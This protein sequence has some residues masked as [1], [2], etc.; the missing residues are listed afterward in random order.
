LRGVYAFDSDLPR[1]SLSCHFS[2]SGIS[3]RRLAK[4]A[5]NSSYWIALLV[6]KSYALICLEALLDATLTVRRHE[7]K[8]RL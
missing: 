4:G 7:G 2:F 6:P 3:G 5:Q 8:C 1:S